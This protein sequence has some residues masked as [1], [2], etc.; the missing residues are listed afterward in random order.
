MEKLPSASQSLANVGGDLHGRGLVGVGS[1][2]SGYCF[3][4]HAYS[5][6]VKNL[7]SWVVDN[8]KR[9]KVVMGTPLSYIGHGV[10]VSN[11]SD[12]KSE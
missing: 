2:S 3:L 6:H 11:R 5:E 9:D 7:R 10:I 1:P 12:S 4:S 8:N